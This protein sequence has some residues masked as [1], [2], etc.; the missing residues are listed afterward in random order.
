M[1]VK[2]T[3]MRLSRPKDIQAAVAY[4]ESEAK[5]NQLNFKGGTDNGT[6]SG[7]G[8]AAA[9]TVHPDHIELTVDKKPFW[10][11]SA[12]IKDAVNKFWTEYLKNEGG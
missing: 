5:K 8:F 10:A 12:M 4:A 3:V 2:P 11:S 7:H 1:K 6:G 9:Y